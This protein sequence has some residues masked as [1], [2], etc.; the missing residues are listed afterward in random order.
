ML[1][2]WVSPAGAA[3]GTGVL[4]GHCAVCS[5]AGSA[6]SSSTLTPG[7]GS[8]PGPA[9]TTDPVTSK[10]AM[11]RSSAWPL[12]PVMVTRATSREK[13]QLGCAAVTWWSVPGTAV[14]T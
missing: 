2:S 6:V 14:N 3:P 10:P 4:S 13:T 7:M 5:C 12:S 1:H 8:P 9:C 11:T